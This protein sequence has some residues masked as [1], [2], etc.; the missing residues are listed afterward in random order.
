VSAEPL[1]LLD[2]AHNPHGAQALA[3][4][5]AGLP[6]PR[7]LVLG[8][9]EDKELAGM[10]DAL[11]PE[12]DHVVATAYAQ[13]RALPPAALAAAVAARGEPPDVLACA[14]AFDAVGQGQVM[15]GPGGTVVVAG[16]LM[17][18]G[19]VRHALLG[20]PSDPIVLSDPASRR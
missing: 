11:L 14:G 10:L 15:A 7:V 8:V 3:A 20:G 18:V 1:V 13:P 9:S 16:S 19:E 4:A 6:R 2:G 5:M 12:V 17:L